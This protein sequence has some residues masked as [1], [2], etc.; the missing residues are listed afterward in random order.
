LSLFLTATLFSASAAGQRP[1]T[2]DTPVI[3]QP[4]A[5]GK[6][7]RTLPADTAAVLPAI[8]SQD[9]EFMRG[10]IVHHAQAVE[11][12]AMIA[13]RTNDP[14]IRLLG[15]RISQSQSDEMQFMRNWLRARGFSDAADIAKHSHKPGHQHA[16]ASGGHD[17]NMHGMLTQKQM[18]ALADA[19]GDD[20]IRLFLAGMIQHH[21]G[22]L[23]MVK[24]LFGSRGSGSDAELFSFATDVDTG[25]R[26]EINIMKKMLDEMPKQGKK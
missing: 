23:V 16:R 11:M 18:D 1:E 19:Q 7:T 4:G 3:V 25:Q 14:A 17:T 24:E 9:V 21:E 2:A 8:T 20:F 5:P 6:P 10:M 12:T 26:A 22:A 15:A 13:S